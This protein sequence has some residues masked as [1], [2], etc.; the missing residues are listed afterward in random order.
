MELYLTDICDELN[1]YFTPRENIHYGTFAVENGSIV[2]P[3]LREGQFFRVVGS[4]Y[5]DGVYCYPCQELEDEVFEGAV[6]AMRVPPRVLDL[7]K[8][9]ADYRVQNEKQT[10]NTYA[11][12]SFGGYSYTRQV[13]E[14]GAVI[15]WATAF[16]TELN[17]WRKLP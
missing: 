17:K 10:A 1:N 7:A 6:Y 13:D 5:N 3:F 8:R 2:A 12:E 14:N 11:S 9:I 16:A 15:G 4:I